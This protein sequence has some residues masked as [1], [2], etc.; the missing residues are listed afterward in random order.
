M[1]QE[2][3]VRYNSGNLKRQG[4]MLLAGVLPDRYVGK[5]D[6]RECYT[7]IYVGRNNIIFCFPVN[8]SDFKL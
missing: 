2:I 4:M 7:R 8:E 3:I 5:I 1:F 6:I